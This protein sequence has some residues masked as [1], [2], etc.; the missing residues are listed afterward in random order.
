MSFSDN[1]LT[2]SQLRKLVPFQ[3]V[4][5]FGLSSCPP[6]RS[7]PPGRRGTTLKPHHKDVRGN[8]IIQHQIGVQMPSNWKP[9]TQV[10]NLLQL[11]SFSG[12][13]WRQTAFL[14]GLDQLLIF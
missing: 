10:H 4:L 14:N 13:Y 9:H 11:R 3:V 5:G 7:Q 6:P 1:P 8:L 12:S 2:L